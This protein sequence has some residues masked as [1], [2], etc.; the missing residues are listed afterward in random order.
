M[1]AA[2]QPLL[3]Q[4]VV[5]QQPSAILDQHPE[6]AELDRCEVDLVTLAAHDT[7]R[8]VDFETVQFDAW[9][10][11]SGLGSPEICKQAG[12]EFA[13]AKRLGHVIVCAGLERAHLRLL[14]GHG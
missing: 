12:H 3:H 4:W 1:Y 8:E 9:L 14:I 2:P 7:C 11:A 10:L 5:G 13:R 6:E